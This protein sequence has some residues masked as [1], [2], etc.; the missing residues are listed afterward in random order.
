M[1]RFM[2]LT[3][4][5]AAISF[6]LSIGHSLQPASASAHARQQQVQVGTFPGAPD[7]ATVEFQ[8]KFDKAP[9][10]VVALSMV[11]FQAVGSCQVRLIKS[12][13]WGFT[14]QQ[15]GANCNGMLWSWVAVPQP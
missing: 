15:S 8:S 3:G 1:Q 14:A 9:S 11:S 5:F 10:V 13:T 2:T 12:Y 6:A 4:I 7:E